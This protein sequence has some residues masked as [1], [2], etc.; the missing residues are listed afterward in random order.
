VFVASIGYAQ[1]SATNRGGDTPDFRVRVSSDIATDFRTR[2]WSYFKLRIELEKGL[3]APTVTDN[4]AEIRRRE[5]AL[6]KRISLARAQAKQ[7]DLFTPTIS[8]EFRNA[9]LLEMN[10]YTWASIMDDNPGEFS[11]HING[12]YPEGKPVSSVPPNIL[13]ALPRLPDD[14]EYRFLG[15]HLILLDT[16][17]RVILDLIPYAIRSVDSDKRGTVSGSQHESP[18]VTKTVT[19]LRVGAMSSNIRFGTGRSLVRISRPDD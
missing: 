16:R 1:V 9:L 2:V 13:A 17:A 5:R 18:E 3:P 10:A 7:G 6:A 12:I 14:I 11:A 4:G 8:T 19:G 15:R